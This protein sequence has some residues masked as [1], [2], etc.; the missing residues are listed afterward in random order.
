MTQ[1][2]RIPMFFGVQE[3]LLD[4][5]LDHLADVGRLPVRCIVVG[6]DIPLLG[7]LCTQWKVR[8]ESRV[9]CI[10]RPSEAMVDA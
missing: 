7:A 8:V 2:T 10:P 3:A 9:A 6:S 5:V 1:S 4:Q